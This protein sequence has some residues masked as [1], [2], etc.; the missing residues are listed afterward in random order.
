M[1]EPCQNYVDNGISV[2]RCMQPS[3]RQ[4]PLAYDHELYDVCEDCYDMK[5]GVQSR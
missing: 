4:F 3:T 1:S 5:R 2:G